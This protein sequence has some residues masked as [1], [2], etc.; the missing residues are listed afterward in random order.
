MKYN[1]TYNWRSTAD[2][3]SA[4]LRPVND[5]RPVLFEF[6]GETLEGCLLRI[7]PRTICGFTRFPGVGSDV[8]LLVRLQRG[9]N[10]PGT[11]IDH[12]SRSGHVHKHSAGW[13]KTPC[14]DAPSNGFVV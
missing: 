11:R 13:G 6:T 4:L 7:P 10:E 8:T 2:G 5:F 1:Q 9:I 12:E 14:D 3:L